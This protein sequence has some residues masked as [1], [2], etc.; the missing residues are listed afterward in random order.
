MTTVEEILAFWF[1][2]GMAKR[3]FVK[4][5]DFDREVRR[6]LL[7]PHEGAAAGDHE[8]WRENARGCLALAILLDQVPRNVFCGQ[9]RAY[10]TD[11]KALAVTR[12]ALARSFGREL[13]QVERHFLYLPLE[14]SETL[15]DQDDCLCLTA[16]LDENP[17]WRDYARQHRDIIARF[18]RFPHRNAV[19]RRASTPEEMEFLEA[20]GSSF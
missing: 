11:A 14:H 10:A 20:P 4:D 17:K 7:G 16:E 2:A 8:S 12:Q 18:G 6:R 13:A 9:P 19:L 3:W 15:A 5:P 1:G